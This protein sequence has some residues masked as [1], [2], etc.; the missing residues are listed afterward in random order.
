MIR[1]IRL[2][3]LRKKQR[4]LNIRKRLMRIVFQ[5]YDQG[6]QHV[7]EIPLSTLTEVA[8]RQRKTEEKLDPA[9]VERVMKDTLADLGGEAYVN[10]HAE[11]VYKFDLIAQ[12]LN[13][14]DKLRLEKKDD[15]S[16]GD[17]IF[18]T[19]KD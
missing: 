13:A 17:I 18:D 2:R 11:I 12:E 5:T 8:N 15:S 4:E 3:P 14:I 7:H 9:T 16:L 6:E 19:S 1:W 10:D